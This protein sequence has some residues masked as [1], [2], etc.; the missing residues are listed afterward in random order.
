MNVLAINGSPRG[1]KANTYKMLK[2]LLEGMKKANAKVEIINL[3]ELNINFCKGCMACWTTTPGKCVIK[4]DMETLLEKMIKADLVIY[5]TP[6]YA[7]SVSGLLKTY[8]D[9]TIPLAVLK[10]SKDGLALD[11]RI[12]GNKQKTLL[13]SSCA[14]PDIKLF[15]PLVATFKL[16]ADISGEEYLGEILRTAANIEDDKKWEKYS[17]LLV[18]AGE[19]LVE[20]NKIEA[21]LQKELQA[22]WIS[23]EEY[24]KLMKKNFDK[25]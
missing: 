22:P 17:K 21:G 19:Q 25:K 6:L 20:S 16:V 7:C 10:Q 15:D 4:D 11:S 5:G 2:P 14:F 1:E 12:S 8:I 24:Q 3:S 18:L 9:R 23:I 13:V